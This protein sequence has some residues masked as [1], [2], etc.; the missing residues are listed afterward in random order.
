MTQLSELLLANP[1]MAISVAFYKKDKPKTKKQYK[2]DLEAQSKAVGENF[3]KRGSIAIEE[4]LK[5]PVLPYIKGELRVMKGYHFGELNELGRI[6]FID[7]ETP[8]FIQ[9]Q[10]DPRTIQWCIINEVKYVLK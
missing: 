2:L 7:M 9:K 3:M 6:N 4:A 8:T 1:R 10:I 5:N